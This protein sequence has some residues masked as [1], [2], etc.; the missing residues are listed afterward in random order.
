M[1]EP[2]HDP[3]AEAARNHLADLVVQ[4]QRLEDLQGEMALIPGLL[5]FIAATALMFRGFPPLEQLGLAARLCM[6]AVFA[7]SIGSS[8]SFLGLAYFDRRA[9]TVEREIWHELEEHPEAGEWI[10]GLGRNS[11][12]DEDLARRFGKPSRT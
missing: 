3:G 1:N 12:E 8:Y 7:G 11:M 4:L 5:A 6:L 9:N 2:K 10:S